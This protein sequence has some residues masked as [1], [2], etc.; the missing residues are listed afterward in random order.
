VAFIFVVDM[1]QN[2]NYVMNK[3]HIKPFYGVGIQIRTTN[4]NNQAA[5]D[6]PK[7]WKR[8][9]EEGIANQIPSKT[10]SDIY[11]VHTNYESDHTKPYTVHL[12]CRMP[13]D[14]FSISGLINAYYQGEI[15]DQFVAKGNLE[16]GA[17]YNA[18]MSIW[19]ASLNRAYTA[20]FEVYGEK[21]IDPSHAEV[22][23]L[24]S[25]V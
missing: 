25:L 15:Y 10:S 2:K 19:Q 7:L 4:E 20:D 16:Q 23:I 21:A 24:I 8:F 13:D 1:N 3:I 18:W 22:N 17:V 12:G 6:I 14:S 5:A 9:M 11:C